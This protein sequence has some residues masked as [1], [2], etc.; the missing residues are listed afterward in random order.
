M[1]F[2][3][4]PILTANKLSTIIFGTESETL[5]KIVKI[6]FRNIFLEFTKTAENLGLLMDSNLRFRSHVT[7]FLHEIEN[8][9]YSSIPTLMRL[10][11]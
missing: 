6:N 10:T 11:L 1:N 9:L 4:R 8:T 3:K 7:Y 2:S 5:Q